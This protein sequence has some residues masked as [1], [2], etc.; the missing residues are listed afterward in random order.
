M[1]SISEK[2][3]INYLCKVVELTNVRKHN[4][5]DKLQITSVDFQDVVVGLD[6]KVGDRYIYFP[7]ECVI[8]KEFLSF[9]NS[10]RDKSLNLSDSESGFFE[11]NGRVKAVR[12]RGEKSCGYLVPIEKVEEFTNTKLTDFVGQEFD[13]IG[14]ILMCKKFIIKNPEKSKS[15][16]KQGKKRTESRLIEGQVHLHVDTNNLRK[17]IHQINP[18][19]IISVTYKTHGTS[20]W[21][22]NIVVK[23]KLN[24]FEKVL[25]FLGINIKDTEYD[26]I[27]GSRRTVKNQDIGNAAKNHFYN[28]DIWGF[29]V[30]KYNLKNILPKGF[31]LYYEIVGFTPEGQ[32]IQ[33]DYDYGCNKNE[34]KI[35]V[36]RI[37]HTNPDGL[38]TELTYPQIVEFC[39][40][41]GLTPSHLFY[42]GKAK[43]M[44][45]LCICDH[46]KENFL[47]ELEKIYTEKKCFLCINDVWEEGI[48]IR[49]DKLFECDSYKL[50]SFNFLENESKQLDRGE[51]NLE[52][53]N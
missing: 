19:D 27:Y 4:N 39:E 6:A 49:K 10:F 50:K 9:T 21:A 43:D 17:N 13:M 37:T 15:N 48:V 22:S 52:D 20:G 36:Y 46:W 2:A 42:Y 11:E 38:V 5:A 23:K 40:K 44:F 7:L 1:I 33:K 51:S 47:L 31:S 41:T 14:D 24:I 8:N 45:D 18:E 32:Y 25:K 16:L 28:E 12:L 53:V 35:E 34:S 26:L 29:T 3:N 30:E